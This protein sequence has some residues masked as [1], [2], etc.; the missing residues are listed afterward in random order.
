MR[1]CNRRWNRAG[2]RAAAAP[3]DEG[4][5]GVPPTMGQGP[6]DHYHRADHHGP[7]PDGTGLSRHATERLLRYS[8][9]RA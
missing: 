5:L 2:A 3:G 6:G 4:A 9:A 7:A 8:G 1:A